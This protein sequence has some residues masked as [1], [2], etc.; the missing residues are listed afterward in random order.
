MKWEG[1]KTEVNTKK[2]NNEGNDDRKSPGH[3]KKAAK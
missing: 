1:K 3:T 2:V